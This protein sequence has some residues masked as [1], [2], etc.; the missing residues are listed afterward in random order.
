MALQ[1]KFFTISMYNSS[2]TEAELNKF[3]N[4]V[5][6][7][8]IQ[9]EFVVQDKNF[10]WSF[11]IEYLSEGLKKSDYQG[12]ASARKR[13]DYKEVLSPEDFALFAKLRDWRKE[14]AAKENIPVY[15]I[16]SNEQLA[17]IVE[18]R[19]TSLSK[20]NEIDGIGDGRITKYGNAVISIVSA[21]ENK[22]EDQNKKE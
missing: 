16:L 8:N 13:I 4:S 10:F 2:E 9:K 17:K 7:I 5:K 18:K 3:L 15:S 20:L 19:I 11:A 21:E 1:Y 22:A 14:A 6:V 12:A